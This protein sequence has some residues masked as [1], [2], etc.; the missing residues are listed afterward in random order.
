MSERPMQLGGENKVRIDVLGDARPQLC[1]Y[2]LDV[3]EER[4]IDL[5]GVETARNQFQRMLLP[6]MHSGRVEDAV[7]VLV[8]PPGRAHADLGAGIHQIIVNVS[9]QDGEMIRSG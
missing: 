4:S 6:A 8:G 1:Q 3:S 5:D 9:L 2:G 7:P